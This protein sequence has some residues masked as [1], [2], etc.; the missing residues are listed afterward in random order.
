[1]IHLPAKTKAR[2]TAL[3]TQ[4]NQAQVLLD[5]YN[6]TIEEVITTARELLDVPDQWTIADIEQGFMAPPSPPTSSPE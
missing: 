3:I 6:R 5:G 1:M 4:R 2:L